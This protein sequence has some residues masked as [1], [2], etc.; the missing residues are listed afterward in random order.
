MSLIGYW[1]KRDHTTIVHACQTFNDMKAVND[2]YFMEHYEN[3]KDLLITPDEIPVDLFLGQFG[4]SIAEHNASAEVRYTKE[5]ELKK[6]LKFAERQ[7]DKYIK[8]AN[9][10]KKLLVA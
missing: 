1:L 10:L 7:L 9:E 5:R 4:Q 6:R 3:L 8:K 2:P